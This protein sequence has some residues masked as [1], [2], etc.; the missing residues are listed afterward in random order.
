MSKTTLMKKKGTLICLFVSIMFIG[1]IITPLSLADDCGCNTA[2]TKPLNPPT[3]PSFTFTP[4]TKSTGT[5]AI[6][7]P[8]IPSLW[9]SPPFLPFSL[10]SYQ[11]TSVS[12]CAW[13][14]NHEDHDH[15]ESDSRLPP[16]DD[17]VPLPEPYLGWLYNKADSMASGQ[18]SIICD[19]KTIYSVFS[20]SQTI[21]QTANGIVNVACS[22]TITEGC[23]DGSP[24]IP[25]YDI[26]PILPKCLPYS[27]GHVQAYA[28]GT[29]SVTGHLGVWYVGD[30]SPIHVRI[31]V[32]VSPVGGSSGSGSVSYSDE[33]GSHS[34]TA[35]GG[36]ETYIV[37]EGDFAPGT[38]LHYSLSAQASLGLFN[39]ECGIHQGTAVAS[40]RLVLS[41]V[42][43]V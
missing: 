28:S 32:L 2:D 26:L 9:P 11:T 41:G 36:Y 30:S 42:N 15:Y 35:T 43:F 13:A 22:A 4:P 34:M 8:F 29:A 18:Y 5:G 39:R 37:T 27:V 12:S 40:A 25:T 3:G 24:C 19:T 17:I 20:M 23:S 7:I 31:S 6:P 33:T 10:F 16:S 1:T 21:A 38:I 14:W